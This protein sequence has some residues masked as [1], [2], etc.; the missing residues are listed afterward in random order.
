MKKKLNIDGKKS[1]KK[2]T[3]MRYGAGERKRKK[4]ILNREKQRE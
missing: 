4:R 1:K 2:K 3:I